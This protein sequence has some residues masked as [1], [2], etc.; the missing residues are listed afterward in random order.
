MKRPSL[1]TVLGATACIIA[2]SSTGVAADAASMISGKNIKANT[3]TTKQIKNGTLTPADM[4]PGTLTSGPQGPQ[5]LPG[6]AGPS[7]VYASYH[8]AGVSLARIF[9]I[10]PVQPVTVLSLSLPAGSYSIVA[11]T[12]ITD[13]EASATTKTCTLNGPGGNSDQAV[14]NTPANGAQ[15][16]SVEVVG[17]SASASTVTL[18]CTPSTYLL[19]NPAPDVTATW[20]K[21]IATKTGS[22]TNTAA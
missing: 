18:T 14:V 20:S 8:D 11:K 2:L 21:I 9:L 15:S 17:T 4:A 10:G 5:G 13:N 22:L 1:G 12:T 19:G 16:V 7:N 3:I 6:Q